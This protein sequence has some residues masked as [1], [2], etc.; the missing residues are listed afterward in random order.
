MAGARERPFILKTSTFNLFFLERDVRT[1][2]M[3]SVDWSKYYWIF[4]FSVSLIG[5]FKCS[6]SLETISSSSKI[7]LRPRTCL[8]YRS[9]LSHLWCELFSHGG[10]GPVWRPLFKSQG[11][12]PGLSESGRCSGQ[13]YLCNNLV[14][15]VLRCIQFIA[16]I[17]GLCLRQKDFPTRWEISFGCSTFSF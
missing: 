3:K 2:S 11:T 16:R 6:K 4:W 9:N 7:N 1:M 17:L 13:P 12:G 15:Q 10:A 8:T 14:I 5:R